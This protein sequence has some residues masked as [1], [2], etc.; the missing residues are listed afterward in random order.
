MVTKTRKNT[1]VVVAL[2][3]AIGSAVSFRFNLW[4]DAPIL[5]DS[6]NSDAPATATDENKTPRA[7]G[8]LRAQVDP[9]TLPPLPA[10]DIPLANIM[11]ELE[12]R[13]ANGESPA[14][15]RIAA[16]LGRCRGLRAGREEHDRWLASRRIALELAVA[17][18]DAQTVA[19]FNRV[20][21]QELDLR[22]SRLR[23]LEQHCEN[24]DLPT[25]AELTLRWQRAARLGDASAMRHYASGRAFGWGSI[26]ES[27]QLLPQ[28]QQEAE[29]M[30]LELVRAGDLAM[31]LQ[32]A[33]AAA[34][35]ASRH[36]SL[37]GQVVDEDTALSVALYR[38]TLAALEVVDS[39][40]ARR[41]AT[42][43][44][45]QLDLIEGGMTPHQL[46]RLKALEAESGSWQ[47]VRSEELHRRTSAY[48]LGASGEPRECPGAPI[49]N[50]SQS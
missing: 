25:G 7:P 33:A 36:Q 35:L 29:R 18:R 10:L 39:H 45:G 43:I 26:L 50:A 40:I 11:P 49:P 17:G 30:A 34:P 15:C 47:P 9:Q 19:A 13:A 3:L 22:E 5:G 8:T 44:R 46:Q 38:R 21:N 6:L 1:I 32:L 37:L 27:A 41:V 2:I 48:G 42:D 24:V 14:A 20:F 28:Y 31:T 12:R 16:E 4:R 23:A